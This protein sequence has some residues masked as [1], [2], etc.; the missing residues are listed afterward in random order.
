MAQQLKFF[1]EKNLSWQKSFFKTISAPDAINTC[2]TEFFSKFADFRRHKSV[3]IEPVVIPQRIILNTC[4]YVLFVC[5]QYI[6]YTGSLY[7]CAL[8]KRLCSSWS[9]LHHLSCPS[10]HILLCYNSMCCWKMSCSGIK[11]VN[12]LWRV[13]D[14]Q[15]CIALYIFYSPNLTFFTRKKTFSS[16]VS[17]VLKLQQSQDDMVRIFMLPLIM[18]INWVLKLQGIHQHINPVS[19]TYR[20]LS[21]HQ[22][23]SEFCGWQR[24]QG[25]SNEDRR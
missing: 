6:L 3:Q 22:Y 15:A 18:I 23:T 12:D 17:P 20:I 24:T 8:Q 2:H 11:F 10:I 9:V 21:E 13:P 19:V 16:Y 25:K 5:T 7:P 4:D 14:Y 1:F